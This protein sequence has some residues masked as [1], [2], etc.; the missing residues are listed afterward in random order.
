MLSSGFRTRTKKCV[1]KL[2]SLSFPL[3]KTLNNVDIISIFH[4]HIFRNFHGKKSFLPTHLQI[5]QSREFRAACVLSP[6]P[7]L[8]LHVCWQQ[9]SVLVSG[10]CAGVSLCSGGWIEKPWSQLIQTKWDGRPFPF[11]LSTAASLANQPGKIEEMSNRMCV[12]S[13]F[14]HAQNPKQLYEQ[15]P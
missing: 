7:P 15:N 12:W 6:S 9:V 2:L 1:Y 5:A 11:S 4:I 3:P 10:G 14:S 13:A 8:P